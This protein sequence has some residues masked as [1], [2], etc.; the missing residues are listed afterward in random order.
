[1]LRALRNILQK[2][3][4]ALEVYNA[5]KRVLFLQRSSVFRYSDSV[6][7]QEKKV[8]VTCVQTTIGVDS[9]QIKVVR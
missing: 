9:G 5:Y 7:P 3:D 8:L 1:M 4:Y 2:E 6:G